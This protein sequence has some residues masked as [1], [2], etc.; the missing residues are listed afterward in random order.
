ML[1]TCND[2]LVLPF[3]LTPP[4]AISSGLL[5]VLPPALPPFLE[6]ASSRALAAAADGPM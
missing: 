2:V 4:A 3:T 6:G 1:G 5:P